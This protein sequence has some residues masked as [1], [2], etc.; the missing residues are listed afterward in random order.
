MDFQVKNTPKTSMAFNPR[1]FFLALSILALALI[2]SGCGPRAEGSY[3]GAVL[4]QNHAVSAD[5]FLTLNERNE[6]IAGSMTI[7]APLYGGG[8]VFGRRDGKKLQFVTSDS[9]GGRI[10]WY[11]TISGKRIDGQYVVEPSGLN[12]FLTGTEKQQGIWSVTR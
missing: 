6:A 2:L 10:S 8:T 3:Q 1:S 5:L 9:N 7:G 12:T 11:G 4:N